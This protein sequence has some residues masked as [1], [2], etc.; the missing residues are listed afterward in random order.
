ME[1]RMASNAMWR[2]MFT[3]V[4]EM[5]S[6][7]GVLV[8]YCWALSKLKVVPQTFALDARGHYIF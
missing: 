4:V 6:M 5:V 1:S 3:V 8:V 2:G 7:F